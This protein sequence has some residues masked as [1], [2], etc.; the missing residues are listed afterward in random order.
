MVVGV[1]AQALAWLRL[2][3]MAVARQRRG[4]KWAHASLTRRELAAVRRLDRAGILCGRMNEAGPPA[5]C[6]QL[7]RLTHLLS[8]LLRRLF[9]LVQRALAGFGIACLAQQ[10]ES[11]FDL[12]G[13]VGGDSR[14]EAGL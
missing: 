8:Q 11:G 2:G 7:L 1:I 13:R 4:R 14:D 3:M 10:P 9:Q 12:E 6:E 5:P